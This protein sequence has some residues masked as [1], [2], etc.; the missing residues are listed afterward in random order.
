VWSC[1]ASRGDTKRCTQAKF[2]DQPKC[3]AAHTFD[4]HGQWTPDVY[5]FCLE[6]SDGIAKMFVLPKQPSGRCVALGT[7]CIVTCTWLFQMWYKYNTRQ[8]MIAVDRSWC[9]VLPAWAMHDGMFSAR[10]CKAL[11]RRWK[12]SAGVCLT[13]L[14]VVR[15]PVYTKVPRLPNASVL[16]KMFQPAVFGLIWLRQTAYNSVYLWQQA[17]TGRC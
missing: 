4:M 2:L 10:S 13:L 1:G 15:R 14:S 3:P 6:Y 8:C 12:Q 17:L 16:D 5:I 7:K 11:D 9:R